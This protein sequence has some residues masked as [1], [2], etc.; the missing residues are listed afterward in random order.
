MKK[1]FFL[2]NAQQYLSRTC[3]SFCYKSQYI[4]IYFLHFSS[5]T[6]C[7]ILFFISKNSAETSILSI[8]V[9][10]I[11]YLSTKCPIL[12]MSWSMR[13]ANRMY[14]ERVSIMR[15][16]TFQT[17]FENSST[18]FEHFR[19]SLGWSWKH[20]RILLLFSKHGC[21]VFWISV[22]FCPVM[23][24]IYVYIYIFILNCKTYLCHIV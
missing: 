18:K 21:T 16:C 23:I 24:Y 15:V 6:L 13:R 1:I 20:F 7:F 22:I 19:V 5:C 2:F 9:W 11:I 4:F 12:K 3:I 10:Y 17:Q 8:T 14:Y